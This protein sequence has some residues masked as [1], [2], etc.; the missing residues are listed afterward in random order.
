M[1]GTSVMRKEET[2]GTVE[3]FKTCC[4]LTVHVFVATI[5]V[6]SLARLVGKQI[7]QFSYSP[8][9]SSP[10]LPLLFA[11]VNQFLFLFF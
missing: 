11:S 8:N 7:K 3:C 4:C 10:H 5:S 1:V 2:K 9:K 6:I